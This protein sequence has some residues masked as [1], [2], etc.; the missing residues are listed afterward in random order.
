MKKYISLAVVL[1]ILF[2]IYNNFFTK[3]MLI[4]LYENKNYK[5]TPFLPDIPYD[6]DTLIL[7]ENNK[8]ISS[9]FGKGNYKLLYSIKGTEIDL[10]YNYEFGTAGLNTSIRRLG[11]GKPKIIL[12]ELENHYYEKIK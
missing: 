10:S 12:F 7:L 11:F 5:Y 1:L 9:Y 8:F 6:A 2:H 4:G 3:S